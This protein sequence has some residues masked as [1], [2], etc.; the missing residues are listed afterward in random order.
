MYAHTPYAH[1][2]DIHRWITQIISHNPMNRYDDLPLPPSLLLYTVKEIHTTIAQAT[3]SCQHDII[4]VF[5]FTKWY[6][7]K[8]NHSAIQP[9]YPLNEP[10]IEWH[11]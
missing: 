8:E 9:A 1:Y 10:L 2:R 5:T 6:S 7:T 3:A 11:T 4:K